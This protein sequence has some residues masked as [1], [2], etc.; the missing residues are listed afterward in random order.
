MLYYS[1]AID[2]YAVRRST[3]P[4]WCRSRAV[5]SRRRRQ[6]SG[7]RRWDQD[8]AERPEMVGLPSRI[9]TGTASRFVN[10]KGTRAGGSC[11]IG[12]THF[13]PVVSPQ[14][15]LF[16]QPLAA[17]APLSPRCG[18][19]R[20]GPARPPGRAPNGAVRK[21][22][23]GVVC[24]RVLHPLPTHSSSVGPAWGCA[25]ACATLAETTEPPV[26]CKASCYILM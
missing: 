23:G 18:E 22:R 7:G 2:G 25:T 19:D 12:F 5:A 24:R 4:P 9:T 20:S 26:R 6:S 13:L 1:I 8:P 11:Q 16:A 21:G 3:R 17:P 15:T 10:L 14:K